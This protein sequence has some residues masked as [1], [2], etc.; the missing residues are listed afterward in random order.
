MRV[1]SKINTKNIINGILL[2]NKPQ[3]IT[4]NAV[5]QRL[6]R[7]FNIRK[8]GHT[9]SLDP[10]ATGMLPICF[11]EAT[12]VCQFLLEED[13]T[14][15]ATGLLGIKTTTSDSL[16]EVI[17]ETKQ[18]SITIEQIQEVISRFVGIQLQTPSMFSALKYQG[19]PLYHYAR[20]GIVLPRKA[21]EITISMLEL[22]NYN[23]KTFSIRTNCSK[24][25][26]IRN[27]V[28]DI[29]EVLGVGAHVIQLHR[30]YVAGFQDK[31]M[32]DLSEIENLTLEELKQL[33]IPIDQAV[34]HFNKTVLCPEEII[35]IRQGKILNLE[36]N[37]Y[38]NSFR[39]LYS[40]DGEF[41]G[42][43]ELIA[44][45]ILKAKRLLSYMGNQNYH[46]AC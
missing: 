6:K 41:L 26:Y 44:P 43:G 29:G 15:E 42:I 20:K 35:A 40:E 5:L 19:Q 37:C 36:E 24:G 30:V 11:G 8:A 16:G 14:Y 17:S 13:K 38:S 34:L 33:L 21:R 45:N 2:V 27:L 31:K 28:E 1:M 4:S 32:L 46:P 3:G 39:R 10:L 22:T 18:F 9:G 12:K 7:I 23:G 25:T